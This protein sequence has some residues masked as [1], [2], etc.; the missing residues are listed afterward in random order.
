MPKGGKGA[1]AD[2]AEMQING[3]SWTQLR[4]KFECVWLARS[5][6]FYQEPVIKDL[7]RS[8][9]AE[10]LARNLPHLLWWNP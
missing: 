9:D 6:L 1:A 7:P 5:C 10:G 4:K 2:D 3:N 8:G